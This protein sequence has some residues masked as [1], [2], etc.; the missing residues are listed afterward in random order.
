MKGDTEN[1]S[2]KLPM[3]PIFALKDNHHFSIM[4]LVLL[5]TNSIATTRMCFPSMKMTSS[6]V[7]VE[8]K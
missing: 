6:E 7:Q 3:F 2:S 8:R 1:V 5:P 4:R